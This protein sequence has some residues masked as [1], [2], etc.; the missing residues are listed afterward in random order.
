LVTLQGLFAELAEPYVDPV[1]DA[2]T[3]VRSGNSGGKRGSGSSDQG[4]TEEGDDEPVILKQIL[5]TVKE[6]NGNTM[7]GSL[8]KVKWLVSKYGIDEE[9]TLALLWIIWAEGGYKII[10]RLLTFLM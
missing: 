8:G 3:T 6:D 7:Q 9:T 2:I 1:G 10:Y 5:D 4:K